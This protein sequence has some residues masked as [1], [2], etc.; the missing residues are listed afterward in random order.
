MKHDNDEKDKKKEITDLATLFVTVDKIIFSLVRASLGENS[1]SQTASGSSCTA[2]PTPAPCRSES[3]L[4]GGREAPYCGRV[5]TFYGT[6]P[7]AGLP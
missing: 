7:G 4:P 3:R 2:D 5:W 6:D 1:C